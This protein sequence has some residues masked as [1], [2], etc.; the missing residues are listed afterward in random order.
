MPALNGSFDFESVAVARIGREWG[1]ELVFDALIFSGVGGGFLLDR[2][3]RP[4]GAEL[5]VHLEPFLEAA[6][7]VWQDRLGGAFGFA[8]A[9]VDALVGVDDE[10]ILDRKSTRL[11]SSH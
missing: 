6:L 2:D 5:A 8:N 1:L 11:K 3:V 7:G 10:H 4:F 9:A